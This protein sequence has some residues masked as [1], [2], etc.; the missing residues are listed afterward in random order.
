MY[1]RRSR[2]D[3]SPVIVMFG[4]ARS[5]FRRGAGLLAHDVEMR[6]GLAALDDR[7]HIMRKP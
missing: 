4:S 7:E 2:I 1:R 5:A 6:A 3:T